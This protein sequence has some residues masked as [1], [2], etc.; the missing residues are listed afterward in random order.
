MT[1]IRNITT[2]EW[3]VGGPSKD[4]AEFVRLVTGSVN[5]QYRAE[6]IIHIP[7]ITRI[8]E[9]IF[10]HYIHIR[11]ER[12]TVSIEESEYIELRNVL[13]NRTVTLGSVEHDV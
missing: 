9:G 11:D 5:G 12:E 1:S 3:I 13:A 8:R 10:G 7:S 6:E 2:G 4:K